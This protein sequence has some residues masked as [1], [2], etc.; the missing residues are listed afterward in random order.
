MK[1]TPD[2]DKQIIPRAV[3]KTYNQ[4]FFTLKQSTLSQIKGFLQN[5]DRIQAAG[6]HMK[7]FRKEMRRQVRTSQGQLQP[8]PTTTATSI[9]TPI[10]TSSATVPNTFQQSVMKLEE[11]L[12]KVIKS[13]PNTIKQAVHAQLQDENV[14]PPRRIENDL[15]QAVEQDKEEQQDESQLPPRSLPKTGIKKINKRSSFYLKGG[16]KPKV[17]DYTSLLDISFKV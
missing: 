16:R 5:Q 3:R 9:G 8:P 17:R 14:L 10:Q 6:N 12:D 15:N 11:T 4:R 2:H 13:L 7:R 1:I